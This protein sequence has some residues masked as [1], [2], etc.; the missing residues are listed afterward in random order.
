MKPSI[1]LFAVLGL[2]IAACSMNVSPPPSASPPTAPSAPASTASHIPL[3]SPAISIACGPLESGSCATAVA[4]ALKALPGACRQA[5]LCGPAL[6]VRIE[7]PPAAQ[8]CPPSGG[9]GPGLHICE[10]IALVTTTKGD[11][12]LGLEQTDGG[13]IWTE[14]ML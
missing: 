3:A 10:V 1:L 11:V 4:V 14:E 8:T 7:S 12:L 9:P 13:W 5:G 6:A 2:G